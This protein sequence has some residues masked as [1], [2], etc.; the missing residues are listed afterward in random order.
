[1][2]GY[3]RAPQLSR[4]VRRSGVETRVGGRKMN[5]GTLRLLDRLTEVERNSLEAMFDDRHETLE[6]CSAVL[7]QTALAVRS[8]GWQT[9]ESIWNPCLFLN[10]VDHDLSLL[11]R[12]LA[13]ERDQWKR[14][15]V[16]RS[17]ALLLFE[18]AEDIPAVF[19]KPFR[20]SLAALAVPTELRA[21][22][23]AQTK[24]IGAFWN[25]HRSMLKEIR[26]AAAAHR[27]HDAIRLL[28]TI[29]RID[30]LKML[31]LALELGRLLNELGAAAQAVITYTSAVKPPE[32]TGGASL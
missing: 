29:E 8:R 28:E 24:A 9:H 18:I 5:E 17:L 25:Q 14:C 6:K 2:G 7:R 11:I 13:H 4:R 27:E 31:G 20:A 26:T 12:D 21:S 15:F 1:M 30:L 10:T 16:A 19:G 32:I 22:V 3:A 23:D